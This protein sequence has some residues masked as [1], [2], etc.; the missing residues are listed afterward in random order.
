MYVRY[1]GI[2]KIKSAKQKQNF[3]GD[4]KYS[5]K[6]KISKIPKKQISETQEEYLEDF[7]IFGEFKNM[8]NCKNSNQLNTKR[9]SGGFS[10]IPRNLK[11]K[12]FRKI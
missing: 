11:N 3:F 10:N 5:E 4:Y 1:H 9:I 7:Q 2:G 8:K 12:K 6:F